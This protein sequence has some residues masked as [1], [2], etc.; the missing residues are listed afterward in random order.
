[1]SNISVLRHFIVVA[2]L[3][4]T[5]ARA[6]APEASAV[7]GAWN[8]SGRFLNTRT[9]AQVGFI[10]FTFSVGPDLTLQGKVGGAAIL[11]GKAKVGRDTLSWQLRLQGAVAP[12]LAGDKDHLVLL[13]SHAD[14]NTMDVDF[15]L[16]SN[17]L[18]DLS[19]HVGN[20]QAKPGAEVRPPDSNKP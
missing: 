2:L 4:F 13:V 15:H 9:Q 6:A 17:F 1:M 10:P 5:C 14:G 3:T 19:M 20:L 12:E 8:G 16:K 11:P 18:L 7:I